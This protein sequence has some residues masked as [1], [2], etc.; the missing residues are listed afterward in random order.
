M[1]ANAVPLSELDRLARRFAGDRHDEYSASAVAR[2]YDEYLTRR[3]H[4]LAHFALIADGKEYPTFYALLADPAAKFATGELRLEPVPAL[5]PAWEFLL[6]FER[7]EFHDD[8]SA[9]LHPIALG[10]STRAIARFLL[11]DFY[12]PRSHDEESRA[13]AGGV[14]REPGGV[15][16]SVSEGVA[17]CRAQAL[18]PFSVAVLLYL[19]EERHR[20]ELDLIHSTVLTDPRA[21]RFPITRRVRRTSRLSWGV[22][23][24]V[25]RGELSPL[26][27]SC[28][29]VLVESSGMTSAELAYVFGGVR[30]LVE[31]ALQG[32]VARGVVTV[33]RRTGIYRPRLDRFLPTATASPAPVEPVG[34]VSDPALRTSVQELIA[35]ADA[36][37]VCPLCGAALPAGPK[38]ILCANCAAQ[39]GAA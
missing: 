23:R 2:A 8:G 30:E 33:D 7:V 20:Y 11:R 36:R 28:L 39:V 1:F 21:G 18:L 19:P 26:G 25:A 15:I 38:S 17:A 22:D 12:L 29:E 24:A 32:L 9:D 34:R 10:P 5:G 31:S 3:R 35:A 16:P 14:R 4:P 6:P 13:A 37:A 27:A